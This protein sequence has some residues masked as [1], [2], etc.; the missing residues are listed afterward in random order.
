MLKRHK[1]LV[2]GARVSWK[3]VGSNRSTLQAG[4]IKEYIS[5]DHP[6]LLIKRD[7][8]VNIRVLADR[9]T[10][11]KVAVEPVSKVVVKSNSKKG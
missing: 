3:V 4:I 11:Q 2:A 9:V 7:D 5:T 1:D 6:H 10:I 8:G